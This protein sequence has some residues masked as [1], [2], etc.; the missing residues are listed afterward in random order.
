MDPGVNPSAATAPRARVGLFVDATHLW[1]CAKDLGAKGV[2]YKRLA[3]LA[4]AWVGSLDVKR[5]HIVSGRDSRPEGFA[6][7]LRALGFQVDIKQVHLSVSGRANCAVELAVDVM[8]ELENL[9]D[10]VLA[11]GSG[12]YASLVGKLKKAGK[13]VYILAFPHSISRALIELSDEWR[14]ISERDLLS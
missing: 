10:F 12:E 3:E 13:R 4:S 5:V 11:T 2:D 6:S 14:P 8:G 9:D 1:N 7:R